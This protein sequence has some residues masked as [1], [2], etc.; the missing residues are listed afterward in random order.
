VQA[1]IIK[2]QKIMQFGEDAPG[3]LDWQAYEDRYNEEENDSGQGGLVGG[4]AHDE[5]NVN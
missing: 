4:C 2:S 1:Q 5:G 3:G